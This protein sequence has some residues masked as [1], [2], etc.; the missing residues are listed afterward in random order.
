MVIANQKIKNGG[1]IALKKDTVFIKK[2]KKKT[3]GEKACISPGNPVTRELPGS[4]ILKAGFS[5]EPS[6][7]AASALPLRF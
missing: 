5:P 1:H 4:P 7:R 2:K 6:A 3:R